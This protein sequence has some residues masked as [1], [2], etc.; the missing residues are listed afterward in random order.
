MGKF[1][2]PVNVRK[3]EVAPSTFLFI[4]VGTG[5]PLSATQNIGNVH[6]FTLRVANVDET[7]KKAL[8]SGAK[9]S[10]FGTLWDGGPASF[11]TQQDGKEV[12]KC[13]IAFVEGLNGEVIELYQDTE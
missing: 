7:Y 9:P 2:L 13:K 8:A 12:F 11:E 5:Q 4:F 1:E 10:P 6:H 3:L